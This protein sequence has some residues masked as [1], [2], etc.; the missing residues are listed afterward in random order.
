MN[1]LNP[2]STAV[3]VY[4][5]TG[6]AGRKNRPAPSEIRSTFK[7]L[8]VFVAVTLTPGRTPPWS[9]LTTPEISAVLYC[10]RLGPAV[11]NSRP[12]VSNNVDQDDEDW[13]LD[14][15]RFRIM[16]TRLF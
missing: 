1:C 13:R 15:T 14:D 6:S 5:P 16:A 12:M 10:A 2:E 9:S 8:A 3:I 4:S 7:P 11:S